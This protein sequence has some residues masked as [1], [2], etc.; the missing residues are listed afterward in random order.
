MGGNMEAAKRVQTILNNGLRLVYGASASQAVLWREANCAPLY[1]C[2]SAARVRLYLKARNSHCFLKQLVMHKAKGRAVGKGLSTWTQ[3]VNAWLKGFG[4]RVMRTVL[5][6]SEAAQPIQLLPIKRV[7]SCLKRACWQTAAKE[8]ELVNAGRYKAWKLHRTRNLYEDAC[9]RILPLAGVKALAKIRLTGLESPYTR[10]KILGK[11]ARICK[12]VCEGCER[13][14]PADLTHRLAHYLFD[15]KAW[16]A[17]RQEHLGDS[18]LLARLDKLAWTNTTRKV[19]IL[20]GGG[21]ARKLKEDW[22]KGIVG[23]LG[24]TFSKRERLLT[25]FFSP[26]PK[27]IQ[28]GRPDGRSDEDRLLD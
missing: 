17:E 4:A 6:R 27:L 8:K 23:F 18:R 20:L 26:E 5:K 3:S 7:A 11:D 16:Q 25:D 19:A 2:W 12:G 1:A 24:A 28:Q 14:V 9:W 15:C 22:L 13:K 21:A 10:A